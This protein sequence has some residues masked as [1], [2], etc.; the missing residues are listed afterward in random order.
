VQNEAVDDSKPA[1]GSPCSEHPGEDWIKQIHVD[2]VGLWEAASF[3][4]VEAYEVVVGPRWRIELDVQPYAE[5]WLIQDGTCSITLGERDAV[6]GPGEVAVLLPGSQRISANAGLGPLALSGFGC[7]LVLFDAVDLLEQLELPLVLSRPSAALLASIDNAVAAS[8]RGAADRIFRT[9]AWAELAIAEVLS[10]STATLPR[11]AATSPLDGLRPEVSS[12]L[13][14]IADHYADPL[15]IRTLAS[16]VYLSPQHLTRCFRETLGVAPMSYVRRH[17][18]GRA[19]DRLMDTDRPV[20]EI[21]RDVGFKSLAHFSRAF[22]NQFG[23]SPTLLRQLAHAERDLR[24]ASKTPKGKK[25][26]KIVQ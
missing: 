10:I 1:E 7:S 16:A 23:T 13:A 9:R 4:V 5:I 21:M 19:R 8:R 18:L 15:D 26:R 11:L 24:C 3:R 17:R 14:Y 25:Q 22:K 2:L 20:T 6:A 12:T